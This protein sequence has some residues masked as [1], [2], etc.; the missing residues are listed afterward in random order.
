MATIRVRADVSDRRLAL[1]P[2]LLAQH[3]SAMVGLGPQH[4]SKGLIDQEV[5]LRANGARHL[6]FGEE[7]AE[8]TNA[9]LRHLQ[10]VP[11][12]N[13]SMITEVGN[14]IIWFGARRAQQRKQANS[15]PHGIPSWSYRGQAGQC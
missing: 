14:D 9:R 11:R 4:S 12:N 3:R 1:G 15:S 10:R 8:V 2:A 13:K 7:F 6:V 5:H